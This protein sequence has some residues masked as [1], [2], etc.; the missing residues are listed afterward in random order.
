M[1]ASLR[2]AAYCDTD[3][4]CLPALCA[5]ERRVWRYAT[6]PL[7]GPLWLLSAS[8][9]LATRSQRKRM[10]SL[11]S[12]LLGL[13]ASSAAAATAARPLLVGSLKRARSTAPW[14]FF[15]RPLSGGV[16]PRIA[17]GSAFCVCSAKLTGPFSQSDSRSV[18]DVS[19]V[20][21]RS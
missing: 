8:D 11:T 17:A 10:P 21:S 15:G 6:F 7:P 14:S 18:S 1:G 3:V 12:A 16:G 2:R 20:P 4:A 13:A 9:G 19:T 5:L